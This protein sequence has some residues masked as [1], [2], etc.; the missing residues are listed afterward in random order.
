MIDIMVWMA[1]HPGVY[2]EIEHEAYFS[3]RAGM[4]KI[5]MFR[6]KSPNQARAITRISLEDLAMIK[7]EALKNF[8]YTLLD[9]LYADMLGAEKQEYE[10][11]IES[12]RKGEKMKE[13]EK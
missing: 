10:K 9:N 1:M 6:E 11:L 2:I 3:Y 8:T 12:F 7:S 13:E 5:T 4:I